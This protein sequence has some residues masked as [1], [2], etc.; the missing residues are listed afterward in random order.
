MTDTVFV[1]GELC[2]PP[3]LSLVL[4][5]DDLP[6][7]VPAQLPGHALRR[8]DEVAALIPDPG[9]SAPGLLIGPVPQGMRARLERYQGFHD[10]AALVYRVEGPEG[11]VQALVHLPPSETADLP[12]WDAGRWLADGAAFALSV[13]AEVMQFHPG[14]IPAPQRKTPMRVRAASRARARAKDAPVLIRHDAMAADTRVGAHRETYA[15]FFSVEEYDLTWRRFDGTFGPVVTRASFIS[16]DA[17]TVLPYDPVRDRVLLIEQFR[18]GPLARGDRQ[19]WQLE[20]V[21]GRIDP[22]ESPEEAARR[23]AVE[24]ARLHLGALLPIAAY[25]PS[26]G[27]KTEYLYSFIALTDL[28]DGSAIIG[29]E[30]SE[31]EDIRGH[32]VGFDALMDLVASGEIATAPLILSALWLQRERP[33]LRG[34]AV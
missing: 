1:W 25:Y 30:E 11:P 10:R 3:L 4:G 20:V 9:Q 6:E 26:P 24:E 34:A 31:A 16:G 15:N 5:S 17:V 32:L 28:P 27:A 22:G 13:A 33:R 7:A 29:G 12:P 21:A 14:P 23:E 18:A 19:P 8:M 2:H